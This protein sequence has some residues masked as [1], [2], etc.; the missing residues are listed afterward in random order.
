M[1]PFDPYYPFDYVSWFNGSKWVIGPP[2]TPFDPYE[3]FEYVLRG[4]KTLRDIF[5][6]FIWVKGGHRVTYDPLSPIK[7]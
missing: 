5:E 6:S 2:V 4:P 7:Q 3:Q 1:T